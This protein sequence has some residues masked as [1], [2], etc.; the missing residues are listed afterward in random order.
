MQGI[1]WP[2][3]LCK[4]LEK[5][6]KKQSKSTSTRNVGQSENWADPDQGQGGF[7]CIWVGGRIGRVFGR[8]QHLRFVGVPVELGEA[9][10]RR[11][12]RSSLRVL[13]SFC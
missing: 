12:T 3:L 2:F 13:P 8:L 11:L 10:S 4:G 1:C 6:R 7:I 9:L 5:G